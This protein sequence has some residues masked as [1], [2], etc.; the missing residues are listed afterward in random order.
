MNIWQTLPD[1]FTALAPMEGV[2]DVVFRQVIAKA[3]RP[4]LFFT[5]FTNVSSYASEKGRK[6]A[7]ERLDTAETDAP[8]IAQIWGKNPDHFAET[9]KILEKLNFS[10]LDINMGCPDRHVNKAGGG[11][12]MIKT[13]NLAVACIKQAKENTKLPVS[14]KT[15]LGFTYLDEYKTWLPLLLEQNLAALTVHLRTRKEMSKVP[16]HY[17]L[18]PEILKLRDEIAPETKLIINGDIKNLSHARELWVKHPEVNGMMI[19]RG[20]FENPFC[21]NEVDARGDSRGGDPRRVEPKASE[22]GEDND[23]Q[24]P[25]RQE[26]RFENCELLALFNYH[27]DLFDRR[28]KELEARGSRYPYEPLKHFFKIYVNNFPGASDLRAKLMEC[29]NTTELREILNKNLP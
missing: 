23:W 27:L 2:T 10:G 15:R 3:G 1:H 4:D 7:L 18:I 20:V 25:E 21:F 14:V 24:D 8:I 9:A 6:N 29:K 17:E 28:A 26:K 12:A 11:A 19:G 16:A 5:E 13:P 22:D